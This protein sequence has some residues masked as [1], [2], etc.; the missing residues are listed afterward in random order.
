MQL[1]AAFQSL[2][3]RLSPSQQTAVVVSSPVDGNRAV[4]AV[5][6]TEPCGGGSLATPL[7]A[8][9]SNANC[10]SK[11]AHRLAAFISVSVST[12]DVAI[13]LTPLGQFETCYR[14]T[15]RFRE[16]LSPGAGGDKLGVE[17]EM[18]GLGFGFGIL[19]LGFWVWGKASWAAKAVFQRWKA[20]KQTVLR[21]TR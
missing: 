19:G 4:A 15:A 16:G 21:G 20:L 13:H 9:G 18:S 12:C 3:S 1:S 17:G 10:R 8:L 2:V 6:Q 7:P 14:G 11:E 5:G